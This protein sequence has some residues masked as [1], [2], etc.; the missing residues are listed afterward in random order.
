VRCHADDGASLE[1]PIVHKVIELGGEH[2]LDVAFDVAQ[3]EAIAFLA[4]ALGFRI[5]LLHLE[6]LKDR[7]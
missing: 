6:T 1:E 7:D 5:E 3:D 4:L 2:A